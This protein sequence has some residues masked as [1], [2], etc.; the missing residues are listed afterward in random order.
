MTRLSPVVPLD[1][2]HE[3]GQFDCGNADLDDWLKRYALTNHRLGATKTYVTSEDSEIRGYYSL[4]ASSIAFEK[5]PLRIKKGLAR[6]PVPAILLARLAVDRR[7][8]GMGVGRSL[9]LDALAR[10]LAVSQEIGARAVLVHAK[11]DEARAFYEHYDFERSPT[12]PLHL[13]L[14]MQDIERNLPSSQDD[15][16]H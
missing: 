5:V 11:D 4:A 6:Y 13:M 1:G 2:T 16:A 10:A 12:D 9:L 7:A 3:L 14:L 15:T 8:Q